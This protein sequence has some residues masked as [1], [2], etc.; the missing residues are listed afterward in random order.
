MRKILGIV[1]AVAFALTA[2]S[3]LAEE[4]HNAAEPTHFP[5]LKPKQED[6]SFSGPFGT[7]DKGQLQRGLKVYKEVCA[8]CHSMNLVAFRTLGEEG[9]LR[10][11][12]ERRDLVWAVDPIDGTADYLR[13]LP[14]WGV[15]AALF[16]KPASK[17][18]GK[19]HP[20]ASP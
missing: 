5:I 12:G 1:A 13:G 11:T 20:S 15:S 17:I 16:E 6:W 14:G 2:G 19:A 7:Y 8:G 18:S 9:G 10:V 4:E 3:T